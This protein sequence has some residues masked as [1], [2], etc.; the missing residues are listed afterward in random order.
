MPTPPSP[1]RG[2]L[3]WA[4]LGIPT[5][6]L[7]FL[8]AARFFV[9]WD[10]WVVGKRAIGSEA[11]TAWQVLVVDED[12]EGRVLQWPTEVVEGLQIPID[13]YLAP[14]PRIAD[15]APH[16][17][18]SRFALY[19]LVES[20]EGSHEIHP[21]T[22]PAALSMALVALLL[23]FFG[24]NMVVSGSPVSMTSRPTRLPDALPPAGQVVRRPGGRGKKG[25]PPPRGKRGRR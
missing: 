1:L 5:A 8:L 23:T 19:Y 3:S 12:G 24:R 14:P 18:K 16:T 22:S 2:L 9:A 10:G 15:D 20:A 4:A 21:T 7:V 11:P 6:V 13:P 25:P 17:R